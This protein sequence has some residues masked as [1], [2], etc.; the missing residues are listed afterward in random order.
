MLAGE[1]P[2][3]ST[4]YRAC[5]STARSAWRGSPADG[6]NHFAQRSGA[7]LSIGS[8]ADRRQFGRWS[9]PGAVAI[10]DRAGR[11]CCLRSGCQ[12]AEQHLEQSGNLPPPAGPRLRG[13]SLRRRYLLAQQNG[14]QCLGAG[15][16]L[17]NFKIRVR[18]PP[19]SRCRRSGIPLLLEL[20]QDESTQNLRQVSARL[21][22]VPHQGGVGVNVD[23]KL[24]RFAFFHGVHTN[25]AAASCSRL[26][27]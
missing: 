11:G 12:L 4:A 22:A 9:N 8:T 24:Y 3:D 14:R 27:A 2:V 25:R 6:A 13:S 23:P 1:R 26:T 16:S 19:G 18:P 7:D 20:A 10:V 5:P 17:L 21:L 15:A